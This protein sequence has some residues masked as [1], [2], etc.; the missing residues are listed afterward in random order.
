[1]DSRIAAAIER[2]DEVIVDGGTLDERTLARSAGLS[3][4]RF[5][6]LFRAALCCT[7]NQY[8]RRARLIRAAVLLQRGDMQIKVVWLD[9]G[10]KSAAHFSRVFRAQFG[11]RP[12]GFRN[13]GSRTIR[14]VPL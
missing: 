1:M 6:H 3:L 5:R 10:F 4:S 12:S 7:P 14:S 9:L 2:L 11:I 13:G 8:A